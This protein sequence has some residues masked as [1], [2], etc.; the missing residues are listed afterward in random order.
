[1]A[2]RMIGA[3]LVG[4]LRFTRRTVV[5]YWLKTEICKD[6]FTYYTI[7]HCPSNSC[8]IFKFCSHDLFYYPDES[9]YM[10]CSDHFHIPRRQ[11]SS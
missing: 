7:I 3:K 1:M 2:F 8:L 6:K 9:H 11:Q 5:L 10:A 4:P